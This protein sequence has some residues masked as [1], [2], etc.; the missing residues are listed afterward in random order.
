MIIAMR[1]SCIVAGLGLVLV[2]ACA[3]GAD[4]TT[5]PAQDDSANQTP[6]ALVEKLLGEVTTILQT[7]QLTKAQRRE[8]V[9]EI[10]YEHIDFETLSRLTLARFWRGLSD[11]DR[12]E[13]I[14]VFKKHL[15]AT[16]AHTADDYNNEQLSVVDDRKE[17]NGDWTV[18]TQ[19]VGTKEGGSGQEVTKVDYRLRRR[20]NHW[21]VIDV[22]IDSASLV[23]NF[24][25]QFEE[26]MENG[27]IDR[28]I[29]LLKDKDAADEQ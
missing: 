1:N 11:A 28:L 7:P 22:T 23:A 26:I 21:K 18:R 14:E 5:A 8:K 24:R 16:Y 9:K 27:G 3:L 10:A 12:A 2:A 15:A 17:S 20:D 4:P 25:S 19:I 6:R 29:K 13:F